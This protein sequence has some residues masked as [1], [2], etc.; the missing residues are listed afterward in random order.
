MICLMSFSSFSQFSIQWGSEQKSGYSG[1]DVIG[2][3]GTNYFIATYNQPTNPLFPRTYQ[4]SS[5]DMKMTEKLNVDFK[6]PKKEDRKLSSFQLI[7]DKLIAFSTKK[8]DKTYSIYWQEVPKGSLDANGKAMKIADIPFEKK[9]DPGNIYTLRSDDGS[10]VAV[11][12]ENARDKGENARLSVVV[13]NSDMETLWSTEG[14]DLPYLEDKFGIEGGSVDND[15]NVYVQG[16]RY[17]EGKM[18]M[19]KGNLEYTFHILQIK[20]G[21]KNI[22]DQQ[23]K[24]EDVYLS[25]VTFSEHQGKMRLIGLYSTKKSMNAAGILTL[26]LDKATGQLAVLNKHEFDTDMFKEFLTEK[27]QKKVERKEEKGKDVEPFKY[28]IKNIVYSADGSYKVVAEQWYVYTRTYTVS[29]S[30]GGTT[31]RTVTM[32]AY[33]DI[34]ISKFNSDSQHQWST[35]IHKKQLSQDDGGYALGYALFVDG[36]DLYFIYNDN[37]KNTGK[38]DPSKW[39]TYA[40]SAKK[41]IVVYTK[42]DE[43]GETVKKELFSSKELGMIA[44][45]KIFTTI[46][47]DSMVAYVRKGRKSQFGVMKKK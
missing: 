2:F 35:A 23:V 33:N 27:Q 40:P 14:I 8:E 45:P 15:G 13:L 38:F 36:E 10:K 5:F 18:S 16:K 25:S 12:L 28:D 6:L 17:A 32:Y 47:D 44:V 1:Q 37:I 3:D 30:N 11:I 19:K 9:R 4:L 41:G 46:S 20:N 31:T 7:G 24:V 21:G 43:N 42:V 22:T 29:T 34:V 39:L 26:S